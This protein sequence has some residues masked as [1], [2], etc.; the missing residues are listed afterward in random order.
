MDTGAQIQVGR[1]DAGRKDLRLI[2]EVAITTMSSRGVRVAFEEFRDKPT[3][4]L[5]YTLSYCT[6]PLLEDVM[7]VI[8]EVGTDP[9]D[10]LPDGLYSARSHNLQWLWRHLRAPTVFEPGEA[11][12]FIGRVNKNVRTNRP[13]H[14]SLARLQRER[15]L[16][17]GHA[18][19]ENVITAASEV[20][21]GS[22]YLE[23][24]VR[25]SEH[26]DL[27]P[28]AFDL[29]RWLLIEFLRYEPAHSRVAASWKELNEWVRELLHMYD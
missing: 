27:I 28:L 12:K 13:S 19:F 4:G 11:H 8:I 10:Q 2:T 26:A 14:L 21:P 1:D 7:R 24:D 5:F 29:S 22:K 20:W 18:V 9:P 6:F 23:A 15:Q 25:M 3:M 17:A 16:I